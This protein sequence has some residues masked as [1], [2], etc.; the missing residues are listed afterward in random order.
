[1]VLILEEDIKELSKAEL[2]QICKDLGIASTGSISTL[3]GRILQYRRKELEWEPL[4]NNFQF[5]QRN[6]I[7]AEHGPKGIAKE[8]TP[9]EIFSK[10][11]SESQVSLLAEELSR[12][13]KP[14]GT[15]DL[16]IDK[17]LVYGFF[18]L[19]IE[20]SFNQSKKLINYHG[21][22]NNAF[23]NSSGIT[24]NAWRTLVSCLWKLSDGF[25]EPLE[26]DLNDAFIQNYTPRR[27]V[28]ID[29]T[30]RRF[31]G[32]WGS[33]VYAPDKP[34]KFGIK[35]YCMVDKSGYLLWFRLH[36]AT[37]EIEEENKTLKLCKEAVDHLVNSNKNFTFHLFVDNYYGSLPLAEYVL[38]KNWDL[39]LALKANRVD[40]SSLI[41]SLKDTILP[42]AAG[43][44]N[45]RVN[46]D[47]TLAIGAWKDKG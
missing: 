30:V 26:I 38:S 47:N 5:K 40:T 39:T 1:M 7:Y 33:K 19:I 45:V 25:F 8:A 22:N 46:L 41:T 28:A 10:F 27:D 44:F 12:I 21:T 16:L 32:H 4:Q 3:K 14:K 15:S 20:T 36:R 37:P 43:P 42:T 31:K 35:Y 9:L 24:Q 2:S 34:A 18:A 17:Y 11:F 23:F 29:E 13:S 6:R